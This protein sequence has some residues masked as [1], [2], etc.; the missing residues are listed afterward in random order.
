MPEANIR[1]RNVGKFHFSGRLKKYPNNIFTSQ[2]ISKRNTFL[3]VVKKITRQEGGT[4]I[5]DQFGANEYSL[6]H[7][8]FARNSDLTH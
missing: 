5:K 8:D 7:W 6:G 3:E 4:Y 2:Y 1:G